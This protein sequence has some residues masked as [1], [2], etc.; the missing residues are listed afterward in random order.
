MAACTR[1]GIEQNGTQAYC[2][3]CGMF[4]PTFAIYTPGQSEYSITPEIAS[5][6]K[7]EFLYQSKVVTTVTLL[8]RSM[9]EGIAI[10][11]LFIAGFG[12]F[13]FFHDL[14]NG[15]WGLLFGFLLIIVG[16]IFVSFIIFGQNFFPHLRWLPILLGL[17][18]ATA[19][20]FV[21]M[22]LVAG[23]SQQNTL[24]M[25][26]GYGSTLFFYGLGVVALVI[27]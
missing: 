22:I 25:D 17:I 19:V 27:W 6:Q 7:Q 2:E 10:L 20:S 11:G 12:L 9:R 26:F 5:R 8:S 23:L 3:R 4:L 15:Y 14:L 16:I 24:G 1:C 13:G 18:G 21:M